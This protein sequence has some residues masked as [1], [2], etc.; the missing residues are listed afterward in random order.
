LFEPKLASYAQAKYERRPLDKFH[1]QALAD[2]HLRSSLKGELEPNGDASVIRILTT[3]ALFVIF[4][5]AINYINLATARSTKRAKEVGIRKTSGAQQGGLV[6]QFL[7][8][9][10]LIS[11]IAFLLAVLLIAL[12][13]PSFNQLAG[14][15]LELFHP[16]QWPV[17][18]FLAV[19]AAA[20]GTIAGLYPAIYLSSFK[21]VH[22]L[23]GDNTHVAGSNGWLRKSLVCLQFTISICLIIGTTVVVRQM[24]YID[25]KDPGFDKE[26]VIVVPNARMLSN[27]EVMEQ[28]I[29]QLAGVKKVGA[30]TG[31]LTGAPNWSGDIRTEGS[32]SDRQI[33]FCQVNYDYLDALGIQLLEGRQFSPE[34]PAD[35]VNTIILNESAVRDLNLA[36]P[37]GQRLV[38]DAGS[39]DTAIYATVVGVV[40]DFHFATFHEPI[41]PFAFLIRNNFF[42]QEDF[43]SK[44]FIKTNGNHVETVQQ[45]AEIWQTFAPQRPFSYTLLEDNYET[46]HLDE[47]RFEVLFSCLTGVGILIVCL[48]LF[49]LIAF[50]TEQRTKEIGIRKILGASASGLIVM[51]NKDF[52]K[53]LAISFAMAAPVAFYFMNRWLEGFV[54]RITLQWWMFVL[55]GVIA[56]A[57][58]FITTG[59]QSIRASL[60]NPIK[61]LRTE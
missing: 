35:T 6:L 33:N 26:H 46:L 8:E 12:F 14:R 11:I 56:G 58:I 27:R 20:I 52:F 55:A 3:I 29:A 15:Q 51:L 16:G 24:R 39:L 19:I 4:M 21:P 9:S 61:S 50:V 44:L 17:W 41:K 2:I 28:R 18:L 59:Y 1:L 48:G 5:A 42:V 7:T 43:T 60:A 36:D 45:V 10:V 37:V 47:Q 54:Y 13:L 49:A 25:S 31:S 53:L 23:K 40:S 22:V 34:Y 32:Q 57:V 30:S 38:W